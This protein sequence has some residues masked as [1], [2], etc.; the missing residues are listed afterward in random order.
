MRRLRDMRQAEQSC[1][2]RLRREME[3][4]I[5]G[6]EEI[7][8]RQIADGHCREITMAQHRALRL[9][10]GPA[11][12]E[13]PREVVRF[14]VDDAGRVGEGQFA[15]F[16]VAEHD[17]TLEAGQRPGE[18]TRHIGGCKAYARRAI[19]DDIGEFARV[20]FRVG[21]HRDKTGPPDREKDRQ[22]FWVI[23][24]RQHDAIAGT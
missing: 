15:P 5:V 13:D 22:I 3:E 9:S 20:E 16:R 2:V 18:G 14:A 7:N 24:H 6:R 12:V 8:V 10:G 21:G 19:R 1:R 4:T 17:E 23:G 11:R